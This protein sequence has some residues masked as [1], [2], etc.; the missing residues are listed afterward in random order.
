MRSTFGRERVT[1]TVRPRVSR[2]G[3]LALVIRGSPAAAQASKPPDRFSASVLA[4]RSQ[5]ATPSA[6]ADH[7]DFPAFKVRGPV[8]DVLVRTRL[9]P[10]QFARIER[11]IFRNSDVDDD[12]CVGGADEPGQLLN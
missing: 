11:A 3:H 2:G 10:G 12:R 7:D 1:Q 5:A 9:R 6:L 8:G 4:W